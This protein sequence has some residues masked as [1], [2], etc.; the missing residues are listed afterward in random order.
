M[1]QTNSSG[2]PGSEPSSP[3]EVPSQRQCRVRGKVRVKFRVRVR[4][5]VRGT[6]RVRVR[7]R[8]G[9]RVRACSKALCACDMKVARLYRETH[10]CEVL[11]PNADPIPDPHPRFP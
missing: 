4:A 10:S 1:V 9:D 8:V 7:V 11:I 2:A 3:R 5:R 6:A